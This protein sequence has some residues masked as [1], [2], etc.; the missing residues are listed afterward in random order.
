VEELENQVDSLTLRLGAARGRNVELEEENAALRAR[1]SQL[2]QE[3]ATLIAMQAWY[4]GEVERLREGLGD[5]KTA[6]ENTPPDVEVSLLTARSTLETQP[7]GDE[8]D[9]G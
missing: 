3:N 9:E 8:E 5:I 1:I 2:E 7:K 6:L 4:E